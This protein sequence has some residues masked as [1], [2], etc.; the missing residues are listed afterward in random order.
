MQGQQLTY[1]F[2]KPLI[3]LVIP[4]PET[5]KHNPI[6]KKYKITWFIR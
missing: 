3:V 4:G 5:A 2:A 6:G 1:A